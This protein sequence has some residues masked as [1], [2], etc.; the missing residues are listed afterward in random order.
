MSHITGRTGCL[1]WTKVLSHVD[2]VSESRRTFHHLSRSF[3][4]ISVIHISRRRSR[5]MTG[6]NWRD[7]RCSLGSLDIF[8]DSTFWERSVPSFGFRH[9]ISLTQVTRPKSHFTRTSW[10]GPKTNVLDYSRSCNHP[11]LELLVNQLKE[12]GTILETKS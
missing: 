2:P 9:W 8:E 11:S 5:N 4:N 6:E 3:W 10:P 12:C 7:G 1:K